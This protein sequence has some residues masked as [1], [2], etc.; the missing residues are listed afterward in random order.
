MPKPVVLR[1][2]TGKDHPGMS[3]QKLT[4]K[5]TELCDTN[6]ATVNSR[7]SKDVPDVSSTSEAL[8]LPLARQGKEKIKPQILFVHDLNRES[9]PSSEVPA[10]SNT[11]G[12]GGEERKK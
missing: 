4:V 2:T 8:A 6:E 3:T 1:D 10:V 11:V 5:L 12:K 9:H 7:S